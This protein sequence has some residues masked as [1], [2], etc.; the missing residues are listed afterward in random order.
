MSALELQREV[1]ETRQE[2]AQYRTRLRELEAKQTEAAQAAETARQ[3]SL[4]EQGQHKQLA[5]ERA[6]E[7]AKISAEHAKTKGALEAHYK[8]QLAAIPDDLKALIPSTLGLLEQMEYI[9]TPAF[10]KLLTTARAPATTTVQKPGAPGGSAPSAPEAA[11]AAAELAK[12]EDRARKSGRA[13]DA[14]AVLAYRRT[15]SGK[16]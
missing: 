14:G 5:E 11:A 9:A 6:T 4:A 10:Q 12:L 7:L 1:R 3:K 2:A 15:M 8:V 13:E 16:Q